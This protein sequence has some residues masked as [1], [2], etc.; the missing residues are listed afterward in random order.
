MI[1]L[2]GSIRLAAGQQTGPEIHVRPRWDL[3]SLPG[4]GT[5]DAGPDIGIPATA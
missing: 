3:Q 2:A 1:A 5:Q 4:F